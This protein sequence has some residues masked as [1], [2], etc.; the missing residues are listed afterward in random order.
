MPTRKITAFR[1][2]H[3]ATIHNF[4]ARRLSCAPPR[5]LASPLVQPRL[6]TRCAHQRER[7]QV[8][9]LNAGADTLTRNTEKEM[10]AGVHTSESIPRWA[11]TLNAGGTHD[12]E[13]TLNAGGNTR[14][15]NTADPAR[16]KGESPVQPRRVPRAVVRDSSLTRDF[17]VPSRSETGGFLRTSLQWTRSSR[18]PPPASS[19]PPGSRQPRRYRC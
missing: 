1:P 7:Q 10:L 13:E 2:A 18:A 6:N 17:R 12:E 11:D 3:S 14:T 5:T 16:A 19:G 8:E 9:T 15:R 4:T